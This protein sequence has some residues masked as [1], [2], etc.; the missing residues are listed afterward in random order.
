MKNL[1]SILIYIWVIPFQIILIII[2]FIGTLPLWIFKL[3]NV[4]HF[5]K[6]QKQWKI[7]KTLERVCDSLELDNIFD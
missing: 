5:K 1:A 7:T 6:N 4:L 3:S 2:S